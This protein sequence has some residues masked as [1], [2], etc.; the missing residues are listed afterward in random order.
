MG[1]LGISKESFGMEFGIMMWKVLKFGI[2]KE[3]FGILKEK[4]II[5]KG[6][7]GNLVFQIRHLEF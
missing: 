4:C 1:E 7:F 5:L 3:V 2:S 6:A